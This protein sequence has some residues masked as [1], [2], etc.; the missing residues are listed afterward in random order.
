VLWRVTA[1][2]QT[3][4]HMRIPQRLLAPV[5]KGA[6]GGAEAEDEEGGAQGGAKMGKEEQAPLDCRRCYHHRHRRPHRASLTESSVVSDCVSTSS[7][8]ALPPKRA[9]LRLATRGG[10]L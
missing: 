7:C 5:G 1:G 6:R 9:G 8:S 3:A 4:P 10:M 2:D